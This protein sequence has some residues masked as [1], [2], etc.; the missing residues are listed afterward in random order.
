M[1]LK[2]QI[3]KTTIFLFP[4]L[5]L[6]S[7][8]CGSQ[9]DFAE[10]YER[11]RKIDQQR[12]EQR[13]NEVVEQKLDSLINTRVD[14]MVDAKVYTNV[15]REMEK[16]EEKIQAD[17][18]QNE[19][20]T[21]NSIVFRVQIIAVSEPLS[22][23]ALNRHYSG[24][25]QVHEHVKDDMHKYSVGNFSRYEDAENYQKELNKPKS[26]VVAFKGDSEIENIEQA[27]QE[28]RSK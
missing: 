10:E 13:I 6:L 21:D 17:K 22:Q 24:P 27:I 9:K 14:S 18:Q 4:V 8:G 23:S 11:Q 2:I 3:A 19:K 26:F 20:A 28:S 5:L 15:N 12:M 25:Y 16:V 7:M 1:H